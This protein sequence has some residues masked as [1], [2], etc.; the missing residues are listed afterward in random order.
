MKTK[1]L[2]KV[3]KKCLPTCKT[4]E[5]NLREKRHCTCGVQAGRKELRDIIENANT[6]NKL[7][8]H[9]EGVLMG[10]GFA[11]PLVQEIQACFLNEVDRE[12]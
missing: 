2:D 9:I 12:H 5:F 4:H 3:L 10:R 11:D 6:K 7:L 1:A 8:E